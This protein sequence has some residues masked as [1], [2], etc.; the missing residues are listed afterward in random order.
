MI[1]GRSDAVREKS[2]RNRIGVVIAALSGRQRKARRISP[3]DTGFR[4]GKAKL[5]LPASPAE[6]RLTVT[7]DHQC[8]GAFFRFFKV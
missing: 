8:S 1:A 5:V 6:K 7:G 3:G 2:W 4:K